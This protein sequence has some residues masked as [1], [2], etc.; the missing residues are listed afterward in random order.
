VELVAAE[1]LVVD[2][3]AFDWGADG[4]LWVVEMRD[5]PLGMDGHGGH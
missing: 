5:Y 2:P 4:R 3:V 1:P